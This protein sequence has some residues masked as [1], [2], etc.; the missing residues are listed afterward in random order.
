MSTTTADEPDRSTTD[1]RANVASFDAA[2]QKNPRDVTACTHLAGALLNLAEDLNAMAD[3]APNTRSGD[4]ARERARAESRAIYK[5]V[6][7]LTS[8]VLEADPN[9]LVALGYRREALFRL[10]RFKAC[11]KVCAQVLAVQPENAFT[12]W[13]LAY[14][15]R[16]LREY[17]ESGRAY[18]RAWE[19]DRENVELLEWAQTFYD[20]GGDCVEADRVAMMG[21]ALFPSSLHFQKL[22]LDRA[23]EDE[24]FDDALQIAEAVGALDPADFTLPAAAG[25]ALLALGR[26]DEAVSALRAA[27][28]IAIPSAEILE[29]LAQRAELI[30][31]LGVPERRDAPDDTM[32]VGQGHIR[33]LLW[34]ADNG[35]TEA[36][37]AVHAMM[38]AD[39]KK[40]VPG[41]EWIPIRPVECPEGV[42]D[43]K[44][45]YERLINSWAS[46]L[47]SFLDAMVTT[48]AEGKT[49]ALP[50]HVQVDLLLF[51]VEAFPSTRYEC[52]ERCY[53]ALQSID[54][55]EAA[56]SKTKLAATDSQSS[57]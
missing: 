20:F 14:C 42:A 6:L 13:N 29:A 12:Q 3:Q 33:V 53:Y 51:L 19:L 56:R 39:Q 27:I 34:A 46:Y 41:P 17:P 36:A 45:E 18:E 40:D 57:E 15:H 54:V 35:F 50:L 10:D 55:V 26:K 8:A 52:V 25:H 1:A 4:T 31:R 2:W 44:E 5:R 9:C 37:A 32:Q 28:R 22:N 49:S 16:M 23:I 21:A 24:R 30:A 47:E 38:L 7:K 48:G 43:H 11:R